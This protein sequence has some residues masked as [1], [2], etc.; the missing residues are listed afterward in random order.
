MSSPL[1]S[2]I[3]PAYN[4]AK[5][6]AQTI[7]SVLSQTY[8]SIDVIVLDDKSS[9]STVD[10][11]KEF[12]PHITLIEN[13]VNIGLYQNRIK[14]VQASKGEYIMFID[15]DDWISK[16]AIENCVNKSLATDA[17]IV[18]MKI[19]RRATQWNIPCKTCCKYDSTQALNACLYDD[20]LFPVSCC[21]K[22]YKR[23]RLTECSFLKFNQFWG[24]DRIFNLPLL[25]RNPKIEM[26]DIAVYNYRWGGTS[27]NSFNTEVLQQ[28]K[29]V[30]SVKLQWANRN[31]RSEA[32][33]LMQNELIGLLNY[34]VRHLI[35]SKSYT[36]SEAIEYLNKELRSDF[37]LGFNLDTPEDIY[38]RCKKSAARKI[39]RLLRGIM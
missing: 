26:T 5:T 19:L 22:L 18:Q 27:V 38:Y 7:R 15:A 6:I 23:S 30:Y 21:S 29:N 12:L 31:S 33:P 17:D 24:E 35:D 10:V 3:I 4:K 32:I 1:V 37:W 13:N 36:D 20:K 16:E 34:H 9:D 28:Y 25:S 8:K 11:C 14:G 2:V 39:K